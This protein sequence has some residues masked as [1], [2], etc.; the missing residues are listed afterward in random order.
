M[1]DKSLLIKEYDDNQELF[2]RIIDRAKFMLDKEIV[3]QKIEIHSLIG[4]IKSFDSF[5]E[6]IKRKK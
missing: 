4:D 5:W 2:K 6:K 3:G 1:N